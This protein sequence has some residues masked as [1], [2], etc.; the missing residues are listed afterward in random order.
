MKEL[1]SRQ[2]SLRS[3]VEVICGIARCTVEDGAIII[4]TQCVF[5]AGHHVQDPKERAEVVGLLQS[6]RE[7]TGWPQYDLAKELEA[8]CNSANSTT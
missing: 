3:T 6:H 8:T 7:K 4:S 2:A 5:A 1:L